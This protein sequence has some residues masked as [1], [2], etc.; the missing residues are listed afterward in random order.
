MLTG[1]LEVLVK[2]ESANDFKYSK[3]IDEA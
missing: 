1:G 3:G 2:P